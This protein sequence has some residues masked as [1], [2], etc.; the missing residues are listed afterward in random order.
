M[1]RE[2]IMSNLKTTFEGIIAIKWPVADSGNSGSP[3]DLIIKS[4]GTFT[5]TSQIIYTC[6]ITTAGASGTAKVTVTGTD[7]SGPHTITSG[8]PISIGSKGVTLTLTFSGNLTP[9]D[10]WVITADTYKNTIRDVIRAH[11]VG[12]ELKEYPS[13]V[14]CETTQSYGTGE[15]DSY[16]NEMSVY[17]EIWVE[18]RE[19]MATVLNSLQ[20]DVENA[21]MR[22]QQ[23]GGYAFD[24]QLISS[25]TGL[26]EKERPF[27]VVALEIRIIFRQVIR[28]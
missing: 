12:V 2:L 11:A 20:Q 18:K 21:L 6:T 16:R 26:P 8:S 17:V 27:G 7:A 10:K 28:P 25:E 15:G 3:S 23:R 4:G 14:F 1:S 24:T 13:I 22:D 5:A 9:N 19:N